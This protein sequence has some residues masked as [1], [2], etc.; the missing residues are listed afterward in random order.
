MHRMR[1]AS[2]SVSRVLLLGIALLMLLLV[3][4]CLVLL[5]PA[6]CQLLMLAGLLLLVGVLLVLVLLGLGRCHCIRLLCQFMHATSL[7]G[8]SKHDD[9][10][11]VYTPTPWIARK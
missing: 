3:S 11:C 10:F 2:R 5:I 4:A 6:G 8:P 9:L 7:A 1:C